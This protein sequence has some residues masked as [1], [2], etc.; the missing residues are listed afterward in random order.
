MA[1]A[2]S[3]PSTR[4]YT[5][6]CS[7]CYNDFTNYA[8]SPTHCLRCTRRDL[9]RAREEVYRNEVRVLVDLAREMVQQAAN[10][11]SLFD[12]DKARALDAIEAAMR[13]V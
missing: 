12:D 6:T 8:G 5:A 3:A 1:K 4:E 9:E 10:Q 2:D 11:A 13:G 7:G